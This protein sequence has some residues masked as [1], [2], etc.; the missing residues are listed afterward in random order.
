M[1]G[2]W[3]RCWSQYKSPLRVVVQC[4]LRGRVAAARKKERLKRERDEARRGLARQQAELQRQQ[5]EIEE[6]RRQVRQ[7]E[8]ENRKLAEAP[9]LLP[10]DPPLPRH[11]F[12]PRLISLAVNLGRTVGLR[13]AE[14][15]MQIVFD[16]L[17]V[18]QRIPDCTSIR[19]WMQRLGIAALRAPVEEAD[20]WV[21]MSDHS[22][23]IGPDKVLVVLGVRASQLPPPGTPLKHEDVRLL[24]AQPG[25]SWKRDDVAKVYRELAERCG[26]PR[27]V[28]SDGA[29]ELRE[30][31]ACLNDRRSDTITLYDFKHKAA[32]LLEKQL[33]RDKR[34]AEFNTKL[35]QTRAAIQQTELAHLTPP[36][37][38]QKARFMNL[39]RYLEWGSVVLWLL[40]H[41]E[42]KT[43]RWTTPQR[44]EEKLGWLRSFADDLAAWRECQQAIAAGLTLI[45]EHGLFH[46]AARQLRAAVTGLTH[47][48]SRQLAARLLCFVRD[49]ERQLKPG[50]RLPMSTEIL[51]S[52][53]ALYKQ[54]ERQ[55]AKGGY[56]S[57]LPVFGALLAPATPQSIRAAFARVSVKDV[58]EWVR[59]NL[60]DTFTLKRQQTY[61]E[62]RKH[63][64]S[65]TKLA[66]VT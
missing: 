14:R 7:L 17:G 54:L 37:Q 18:P 19:F 20:D 16:W 38:K 64:R 21:W 59:N 65:A 12:G 49:A 40:E 62:Y 34:F 2:S 61:R 46:G 47:A 5:C 23:Q 39:D 1:N 52:S 10:D 15:T 6:L 28:V 51:E 60:G 58:K 9:A 29:V 45:N 33:A 43:R 36:G 31:T 42:A 26:P 41:P 53:F 35:G 32:K 3:T 13:G 22:N 11:Q 66:T 8:A 30:P 24:A 50:E 4:L 63:T 56:T 48:V 44:L 57:L 55:H 25:T 27:A